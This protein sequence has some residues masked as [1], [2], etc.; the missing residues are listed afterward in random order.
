L[1]AVG[2]GEATSVGSL[3]PWQT[4]HNTPPNL[5]YKVSYPFIEEIFTYFKIFTIILDI[6]N[7][8]FAYINPPIPLIQ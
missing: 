8:I 3:A 4:L 6:Q 1:F 2:A 5:N 7:G